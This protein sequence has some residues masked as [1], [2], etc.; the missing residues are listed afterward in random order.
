MVLEQDPRA[1]GQA[2]AP[3]HGGDPEGAS[4][5]IALQ[6]I[7]GLIDVYGEHR[8]TDILSACAN[9]T[10]LRLGDPDTA[11][12]AERFFGQ[13]RRSETVVS[14]SWGGKGGFSSSVQRSLVDRPMLLASTFL[15]LGFTGLPKTAVTGY[16]ASPHR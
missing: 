15:N 9:K 4:V 1:N 14:E 13:V 8:A 12:W 3:R 11:A 6:S 10:F 2:P 5:L 16:W 7:A